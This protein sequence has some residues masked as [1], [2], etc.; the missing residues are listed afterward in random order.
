MTINSVS[1]HTR[2]TAETDLFLDFLPFPL[3]VK[4]QKLTSVLVSF[5][6]TPNP[7]L[8]SMLNKIAIAAAVT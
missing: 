2:A 7:T 8:S 5:Q 6:S 4:H 1:I 3:P